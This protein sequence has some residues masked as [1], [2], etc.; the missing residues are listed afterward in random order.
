MKIITL[1]LNL[2]LIFPLF[3]QSDNGEILLTIDKKNISKDE[4]IHVYNKNNS[5]LLPTN[6]DSLKLQIDKFI[7]FKLKVIEAEN[8]GLDKTDHFIKEF[9]DYKNQLAEP[10]LVDGE[11]FEKLSLEAYQRVKSE[12]RASHILIKVNEFASPEDTLIAYQKAMNIKARLLESES[13]ENVAKETSDDPT[14]VRN[15][16]DLW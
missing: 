4:F 11:T 9:A 3:S 5:K 12:V 8:R 7:N 6:K 13:F 1:I 16:G 2:L 14:A 15:G 10:F